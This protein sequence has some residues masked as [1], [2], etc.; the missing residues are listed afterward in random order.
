[1]SSQKTTH[2]LWVDGRAT[3]INLSKPTP[4]SVLLSWALPNTVRA[5]NGA[6][7]LL[8]ETPFT[9]DQFPTDGKKYLAS[10]NWASQLDTING[11]AVV[12]A[13]YGFFG[14]D[15]TQDSVT[16]TNV[17]PDKLYY[18]SI[19]VASNV[20]QYHTFGSQSYPIEANNPVKGVSA[21]AGSIQTSQFAPENPYN[22]QVYF[23]PSSSAVL[24]WNDEQ[25]AWVKTDQETIPLGESPPVNKAQLFYEHISGEFKYFDGVQ[26]VVIN[27]SN[28]RVK[29]GSIWAPFSSFSNSNQTP[30]APVVGDFIY[31][32][33]PAQFAAPPT[34]SLKFYS[35]GQWFSPS[36]DLVQVLIDGVFTPMHPLTNNELGD[37]P[38]IPTVGDF[39]YKTSTK[40]LMVWNGL[41]WVKADTDEGGT[42]PAHKISI[43]TDGSTAA[44]VEL[45]RAI[46]SRLGYPSVCVELKEDH[47]NDSLNDALAEF[48][49]RA[50]NA[51]APGFVSMTLLKGQSTYYLNDPRDESNRIVSIIKIHRVNML[52]VSSLSA[53]NG[54]Y[55]QAFFNQLYQGST[56][57]IL[58]IHLMNQLS[59]AYE[60]IFAGNLTFTWN[61]ASRQMVVLRNIAQAKER[62]VLEVTLEKTEQELINDRYA[63][64]WIKDWAYAQA[65]EILGGI[66]SK[67]GSLPSAGGALTL[68]G[69]ELLQS[70]GALK[71]ELLRQ[72]NDFEAGQGGE[73][74]NFSFLIG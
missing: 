70:A 3:T 36:P 33:K 60:K 52:G 58:S 50:S 57:D 25:S 23:D 31:F 68:N 49:R 38:K 39:F 74:G 51:L 32:K 63:G 73:H 6:I 30:A 56:V 16:V 71:A 2:D 34:W 72:I 22:G 26:Y 10:S 64:L 21:F 19:H 17:D 54:L 48:R 40:D 1:M 35:L 5:Y 66:R 59:E 41:D 55:A 42:P 13:V 43:G 8:S 62:V 24:I 9:A 47:F 7:V 37:A 11:A 20:L 46:K 29:M 12:A 67:Y 65:L 61:E 18:A 45:I 27:P 44:R 14:D 28:T 69:A 4:T 15:I 53:E